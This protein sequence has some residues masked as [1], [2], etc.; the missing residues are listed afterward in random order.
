M[1]H[2]F[3]NH[4]A[5]CVGWN[6]YLETATNAGLKIWTQIAP[7]ILHVDVDNIFSDLK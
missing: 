6:A 1:G 2:F 7:F 3:L 4:K 5:L